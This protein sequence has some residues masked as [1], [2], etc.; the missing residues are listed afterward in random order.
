MAVRRS[1]STWQQPIPPPGGPER[2]ALVAEIAARVLALGENRLRVGI[3]GFTAAGKTSFGHELGERIAQAGRPVLRS[4]LD[5]FK[6][7]WRDR[8][9]Y[10][11]ESGEGYYRNAYDYSAAAELLLAPAGPE[12]TGSCALCLRDPF[13]QIDHSAERVEAAEDAVLIVDGVFAF[14][15]EIDRYWDYRVW[16]EIDGDLSVARGAVRDQ[17]WAGS[18]A[19]AIHRDRYL[20][21]ERIYLAE[22][23]PRGRVDVVIDNRVFDRPQATFRSE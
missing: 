13:T 9:L 18:N 4:C 23:D 7:P 14:R 12:G 2:D 1:V 16:I 5:D 3:D 19:E 20:V 11:R 21:A 22:A 10:D 15:P 17:N 6:K 8:H